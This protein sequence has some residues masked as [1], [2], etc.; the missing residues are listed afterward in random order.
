MAERGSTEQRIAIDLPAEVAEMVARVTDQGAEV[1]LVGGAVRDAFLERETTDLDFATSLRPAELGRIFP[2]ALGVDE[3]FGI[4]SLRTDSHDVAFVTFRE[5][6]GYSDHRHPDE[7]RFSDDHSVDAR[8]RD[9]TVNAIY[10]EPG[11]GRIFDP[12]G[13]VADLQDGVLRVIGNARERFEE[14]ALRMLRAVRF[15]AGTDLALDEDALLGLREMAGLLEKLSP[16]RMFEELTAMFSRDGRGKA[17]RLLVETGLAAVIL[18]EVVELD[19]VEQP[20]RFHPEG[21]VLIHTCMVL[22]GVRPADPSQAWAAVLHDIGKPAT[23]E[24]APDRIRFSK[25]DVLSARMAEEVLLRLHAPS[26]L[27]E[28]VVEICRDHIRFASIPEMGPSKRERWMR[29]PRFEQHLEFH[30]ADCMGS[31]GLLDIYHFAREAY[32]SLPA[33]PPPPLCTGKDV[34]ELGVAEGPVVGEILRCVQSQLD[35]CENPGRSMAL[36]L[37]HEAAQPHIKH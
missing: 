2:E 7:V 37:L 23:F 34:I 33:M 4:C 31:H 32:E 26:E 18:P 6:G 11:S 8:R 30:R 9:F 15:S 5:E 36:A 10:V 22:D 12:F 25:H 19:G 21:D 35:D 3:K 24:R 13:G 20:P 1:M 17:L 29:S 14:D 27:R 16:E 28:T